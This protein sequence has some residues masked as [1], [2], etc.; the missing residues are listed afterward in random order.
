[1]TEKLQEGS[2]TFLFDGKKKYKE[3]ILRGKKSLQY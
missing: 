2:E 3:L 1:M